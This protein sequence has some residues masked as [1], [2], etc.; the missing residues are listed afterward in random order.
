MEKLI[1]AGH[2]RGYIREPAHRA[3]IAPIVE[4]IVASSK[5]LPEPRPTIIYILGGLVDDLYQSKCQRRKLL[6]ATIV[7]TRVN[8]INTPDNSRAMQP[9]DDPISFPPIN[10]SRVITPHH[11]A[12]VLTLC[13]DNFDVLRVLVDSGSATNLLQLP[14]FRQMKVPLDKLFSAGRI[15]SGFNGATTL[16]IWD[17]ALPVKVGAVT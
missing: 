5:L 13:I 4:R 8:T 11:D 1:R 9:V 14:A 16:T 6:R 15:L 7:Q 3:K 12:L 10:P 2:L 17:I